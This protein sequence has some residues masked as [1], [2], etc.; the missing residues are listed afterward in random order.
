MLGKPNGSIGK[1]GRVIRVNDADPAQ[2]LDQNG[3]GRLAEWRKAGTALGYLD[4]DGK[5]TVAGL[6]AIIASQATGDMMYASSATAWARLAAGAEGNTFRLTSGLPV[7]DKWTPYQALAAGGQSRYGAPG[8]SQPGDLSNGSVHQLAQNVL[9]FIPCFTAEALSAVAIVY[10]QV[11]AGSAGSLIRIGIY[12][13]R[14]LGTG[15]TPGAV[16]Y[17]SGSLALDGA[18]AI[19]ETVIAVT[20]PRGWFFLAVV[21]NSTAGDQFKRFTV[22]DTEGVQPPC[23]VAST[24][25][26]DG[27]PAPF[28]TATGDVTVALPANPTITNRARPDG[29]HVAVWLKF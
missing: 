1:W 7:W 18:N 20:I 6:A 15:L 9:S 24:G 4:N 16:L 14:G 17:D 8:W 12:A 23:L 2:V 27:F 3:T 13:E 26:N 29:H 21:H 22:N 10:N 11:A 25:N 19:K 28:L 5:L